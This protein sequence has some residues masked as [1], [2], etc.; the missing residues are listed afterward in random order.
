MEG[1]GD[2]KAVKGDDFFNDGAG[3]MLE[4]VGNCQQMCL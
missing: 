3:V 4:A 2:E 1:L